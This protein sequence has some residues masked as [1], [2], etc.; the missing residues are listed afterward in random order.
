MSVIDRGVATA[1]TQ[2]T[3]VRTVGNGTAASSDSEVPVIHIETLRNVRLN[4]A[5]LHEN[6]ICV[7]TPMSAAGPA[8]KV[9][10][11]RLLQSMRS[12]RWSTLGITSTAPSEGKTLTAINLAMSLARDVN[13]TTILADFDLRKPSIAKYLGVL[14]EHTIAEVLDGVVPLEQLLVR[15]GLDRLGLLL[16]SV[17]VE[18]SSELLASP[19][20][21]KLVRRLRAGPDRIVIYD[22]PP[23][24]AGDDVLAFAP[25]VDALLL[26]L[27]EGVTTR[28]G[29]AAAKELITEFNLI[30]TVLNRSVESATNHYYYYGYGST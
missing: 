2:V 16:N 20:M 10:R 21:A 22:L 14:P 24:L 5:L 30:G 25:H 3:D 13:T 19:S 18:N 11:T 8:Y 7:D 27:S 23:V 28:E 15:P 17:P 26:V 1:R 29:L 12:N 4:S 6:R 9:L